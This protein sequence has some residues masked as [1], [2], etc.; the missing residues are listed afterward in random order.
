MVMRHAFHVYGSMFDVGGQRDERRKWIQCFNDVTAIIFVCASS[1]YNLV[2]WEDATQ[3]RLKESLA[4]FKNIW[5]NRWLKTISVILFLNKQDLLAEKIKSKRHLLETYFPE[6]ANYQL[7]ADATYDASDDP[8]VVRANV[9]KIEY[10]RHRAQTVTKDRRNF[11]LPQES[12]LDLLE[13]FQSLSFALLEVALEAQATENFDGS[14]RRT[15]SLL[16]TFYMRSGH[17]EHPSGVQRLQGHN[18]TYPSA[19]VRAVVGGLEGPGAAC[20]QNRELRPHARIYM[21]IAYSCGI[22]VHFMD[23]LGQ[24]RLGVNRH[25]FLTKITTTKGKR[26]RTL[27]CLAT[28]SSGLQKAAFFAGGGPTLSQYSLTAVSRN[29]GFP[30][31]PTSCSSQNSVRIDGCNIW[32]RPSHHNGI[33]PYKHGP[34]HHF[35]ITCIVFSP[36]YTAE[37]PKPQ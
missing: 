36:W 1:S 31:S 16:P 34:G 20:R 33:Q 4:L 6:F 11:E 25:C 12:R 29:R 3:N 7:P 32:T 28:S 8:A 15:S 9:G 37:I 30:D 13:T 27:S 17:G 10:K 5:N 2:L 24:P 14:W 23:E 22:R 18:P 21:A 19:S 26:M 35:N